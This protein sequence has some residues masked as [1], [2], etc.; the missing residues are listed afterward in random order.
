MSLMKPPF[1]S[2]VCP[3]CL[4]DKPRTDYYKKVNTVSH[5]CKPCSLQKIRD[6][7][8]KYSGKYRDY[9]NDWRKTKYATDP[10]YRERISSQKAVSYQA[11]KDQINEQRR[12]RWL[13]D[14]ECPAR[15]HYRRKD[16]KNRTPPWVMG[17]DLM[18]VYSKCPKGMH[19]DHI[20]PLKGLVDGRPVSGLHV[21]WNLQ[22]LT[23]AENHKKYN[24]VSEK[25]ALT[26]LG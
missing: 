22:Y 4:I 2:K 18:A 16:V 13:N 9:Q 25:D 26:L 12:E 15:L 8:P 23:P 20:V 14:P 10:V 21:P 3:S 19:V 11:R 5:L 7:A 24:R 17:K 6:A 1:I